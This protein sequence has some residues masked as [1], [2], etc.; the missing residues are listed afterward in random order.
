MSYPNRPVS[1][2]VSIISVRIFKLAIKKKILD[3]LAFSTLLPD[4]SNFFSQCVFESRFSLDAVS[5]LSSLSPKGCCLSSAETLL[6][7]LFM[8]RVAEVRNRLCI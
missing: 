8:W 4:V 3:S 1:L 5:C 2:K 6:F 7:K